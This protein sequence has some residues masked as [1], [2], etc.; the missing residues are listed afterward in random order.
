MASLR[1]SDGIAMSVNESGPVDAPVT[2]LLLHGWTNDHT[3]WDR[4]LSTLDDV[5]V[6]RPDLR[7]H[8]RSERTPRGTAAIDRLGDDV[9]E[10]IAARVPTGPI[11]LV[12]HS[13]GAMAMM[14]L[15]RRHPELVAKR[16]VG[17]VFVSTSSGGLRDVTFGLPPWLVRLAARRGRKPKSETPSPKPKPVN[18]KPSPGA[19]PVRNRTLATLLI[20]WLAFGRRPDRAAVRATVDQ[21][22]MADRHN[23]GEFRS[24]LGKHDA[25]EAF[26]AYAAVPSV[27]MVGGRDR[28]T[29][30]S[31]A[32]LVAANLPRADLLV[33]PDNGHMLPLEQPDKIAEQ[34]R[35]LIDHAIAATR[36]AG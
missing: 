24:A 30:P 34:I 27:V 10:L 20:R 26:D 11:V 13:M 35:K 1:M 4:V 19:L 2:V 14:T 7:G 25:A 29:P 9:A 8:G 23:A 6:V 18:K 28:M 36:G 15:A 22:A 33:F 12:G 16:V 3:V 5:R 21:V 31:H 17:A 32:K